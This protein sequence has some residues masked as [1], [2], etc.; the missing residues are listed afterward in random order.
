MKCVKCVDNLKAFN[1][2]HPSD[3][4]INSSPEKPLVILK[5]NLNR[6]CE[7]ETHECGRNAIF[8]DTLSMEILFARSDKGKFEAL[9]S[10]RR[11]VLLQSFSSLLVSCCYSL[12]AIITTRG[13]LSL[14]PTLPATTTSPINTTQLSSSSQP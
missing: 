8:T 1:I 6:C 12:Q 2:S 14:N 5:G 7:T 11:H 10:Q 4:I 13:L 9:D 3:V